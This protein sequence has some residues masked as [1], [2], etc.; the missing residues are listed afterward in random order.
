VSVPPPKD[1]TAAP[2]DTDAVPFPLPVTLEHDGRIYDVAVRIFFDGVEYLG[3]LWFRERGA[4]ELAGIPDRGLMPGRSLEESLEFARRFRPDE[5]LHRLQRALSEKRRY[6][7][8]RS[9]TDDVL[10]K[11]RYLNQL[12]V[13]MRAGV[14]DVEGAAQEIDLTER[15]LH[16]L[17]KQMR[18]VAGVED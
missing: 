9:T 7:E 12:A 8:L 2:R 5:L 4:G 13:A 18:S 1:A 6:H 16:E 15:Q 3:R 11:V 17:V 10:S 14:L